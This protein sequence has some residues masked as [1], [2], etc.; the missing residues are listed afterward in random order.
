MPGLEMDPSADHDTEPVDHDTGPDETGSEGE[1][2]QIIHVAP[3]RASF[4]A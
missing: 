3:L 1:G 4:A 2:A